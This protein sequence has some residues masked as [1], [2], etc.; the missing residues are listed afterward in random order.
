[1]STNSFNNAHYQWDEIVADSD[2]TLLRRTDQR[3]DSSK[4]NRNE[5]KIKDPTP[6]QKLHV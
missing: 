5:D 2:R 4:K 1:M 3:L 6:K